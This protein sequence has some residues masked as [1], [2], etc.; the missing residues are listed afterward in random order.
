MEH[1]IGK[2]SLKFKSWSRFPS[3]KSVN[4]FGAC[5]YSLS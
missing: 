5:S 1:V 3:K 4:F 2:E